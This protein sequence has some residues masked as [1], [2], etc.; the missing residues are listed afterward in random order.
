MVARIALGPTHGQ[1]RVP[2]AE[3]EIGAP[4]GGVIGAPLQITVAYRSP[5]LCKSGKFA[6]PD[7]VGWI[8]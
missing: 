8:V 2:A 6:T 3:N 5:R 7:G 1:R 4:I